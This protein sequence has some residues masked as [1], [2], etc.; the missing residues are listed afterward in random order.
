MNKLR[1]GVSHIY[2]PEYRC[3]G[4]GWRL[5]FKNQWF[6]QKGNNF[7]QLSFSPNWKE[8]PHPVN[9]IEKGD[10]DEHLSRMK[11]RGIAVIACFD[12]S[13]N[14]HFGTAAKSV[15]KDHPSLDKTNPASYTLFERIIKQGVLRYGSVKNES[16]IDIADTVNG[17]PQLKQSGLN[18]LEYVQLLN[19]VN[20]YN[21]KPDEAESL[22]GKEYAL[23]FDVWCNAIW[24]I[25]ANMK[26][27]SAPT[28]RFDQVWLDDFYTNSNAIKDARCYVS[29]NLY[30]FGPCGYSHTVKCNAVKPEDSTLYSQYNNWL[31]GKGKHGLVTEYGC[32]SEKIHD[33]GYPDYEGMNK[34]QAQAK[35]INDS[36]DSILALSN[37]IGATFYQLVDDPN[38]TRFSETGTLDKDSTTDP[39]PKE[40]YDLV[41]NHFS[42]IPVPPN[43]NPNPMRK[44]F[45]TTKN[46]VT[47]DAIEVT[48]LGVFPP[49][50]YFLFTDGEAPM[51]YSFLD[52]AGKE[53]QK[54]LVIGGDNA[55]IFKKSFTL[56]PGSYQITIDGNLINFTIADNTPIPP[57]EKKKVQVMKSPGLI[58]FQYNP[59]EIEFI[60]A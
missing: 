39:T 37:I 38:E 56:D 41:K 29:A 46:S 13:Y 60:E 45:I 32:N 1:G 20:K 23:L 40:S 28:A 12:G 16:L 2:N 10:L 11:A 6:S 57:A 7:G 25:D 5:W 35:H 21:G 59:D 33:L 24:L 52:T 53:G 51:N 42:N 8:F 3:F 47:E 4:N 31:V 55:G 30:L 19:E 50:V 36:T 34:F 48:E 58:S 27:I 22:T 26:I 17:R 43:P 18:T 9:G 44:L 14:E 15:P 49:G 54:P